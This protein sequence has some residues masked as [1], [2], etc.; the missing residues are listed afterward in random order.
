[1]S[2]QLGRLLACLEEKEVILENMILLLD[3]ERNLIENLD[4]AGV[5]E[6]NRRKLYTLQQLEGSRRACGEAVARAAEELGLP[7]AS[8]L[9]SVIGALPGPVR[10]ELQKAQDRL[11][12]LAHKLKRVNCLNRDLLISSLAAI[13]RSL[14]YFRGSFGVVTTYSV[15]GRMLSGVSGGRYLH[16]EM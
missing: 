16:G 7:E 14:E 2:A 10:A 8:T 6:M 12:E 9:S 5:E 11:L 1:M 4:A 3:E 13:N 15:E